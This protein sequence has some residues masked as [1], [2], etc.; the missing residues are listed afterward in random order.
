M[1][2]RL[3]FI[4]TAVLCTVSSCLAEIKIREAGGILYI[5]NATVKETEDL[6][7]K[8]GYTRF[9][10]L[11]D[12]AYP[13]IFLKTLPSDFQ[14]I[15]SQKYRNELFIRILT[16]LALKINEEI[17]NERNTLLRIERH[18]KENNTISKEEQNKLEELALKYDYFTR[19]TEINRIELQIDNLKLRI[20]SVPPSI[21][22]AVAAMESNWGFSRVAN[23]ANSLYKEKVWYTNEG[24]EPLENKDDG[25]RFKIFNSLIESM[26]SFALTF[27][28]NIN[29]ETVW[30]ARANLL[31]RRN[32]TIGES[33]AYSLSTASN[34]PNF[35]GILDYTTAFYDFLALDMGHLKKGLQK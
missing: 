21:L 30:N 13:A 31:K 16:P 6:F 2:K 29:Y 34:L 26:R 25:Y 24:L 14:S 20:N 1:I 11:N 35:V 4:L 9:L 22:I 32:F 19:Q 10:S 12:G 3:T 33:I 7:S 23:K 5:E 28:S 18:F 27:N 8:H 15:K 17:A